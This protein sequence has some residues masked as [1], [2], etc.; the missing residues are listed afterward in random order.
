MPTFEVGQM[1]KVGGKE[2]KVLGIVKYS[3]LSPEYSIEMDAKKCWLEP[4]KEG[5][6]LWKEASGE[7]NPVVVAVRNSDLADLTG[8]TYGNFYVSSHGVATAS[9]SVGNTWGIKVGERVELWR[10]KNMADK[11]WPL[12]IVE[13]NKDGVIILWAGRYVSVE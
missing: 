12:F 2:T 11:E 1:I 6:K 10:G 7:G 8:S 9:E 13:R 5:Q 4:N 3:D